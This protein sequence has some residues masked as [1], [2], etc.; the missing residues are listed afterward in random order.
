MSARAPGLRGSVWIEAGGGAT[1]GRMGMGAAVAGGG[2]TGEGPRGVSAGP[3]A[4]AA[5]GSLGAGEVSPVRW[6]LTR[7]PEG[8]L[9]PGW[10]ALARRSLGAGAGVEALRTMPAAEAE[11]TAA[12]GALGSRPRSASA[13]AWGMEAGGQ[14][15]EAGGGGD[16]GGEAGTGA[17]RAR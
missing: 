11:A 17:E 15:R 10:A 6:T 4:G 12:D 8:G 13:M 9:G 1:A 16:G 5:R 14:E 7:R 2:G 3:T